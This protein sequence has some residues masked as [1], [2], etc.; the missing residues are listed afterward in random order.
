MITI[1][2]ELENEPVYVS[3]TDDELK[4]IARKMYR[5]ETF[6]SMQFHKGDEQLLQNVFLVL[7]LSPTSIIKS[8][9]HQKISEFYG[10]VKPGSLCINGYPIV[11]D[12]ELLDAIDAQKV[13]E[14][15]GKIFKVLEDL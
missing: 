15:Y 4:E 6:C 11:Y 12:C 7:A 3:K 1:T 8:L 5:G 14:Y 10:T 9:R 13:W 2:Y